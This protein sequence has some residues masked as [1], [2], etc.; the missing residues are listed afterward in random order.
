MVSARPEVVAEAAGQELTVERLALVMASVKGV[1]L[2]REAAEVISRAWI[3]YTLLAQAVASGRNLED[4]ATAAAVLWPQV[5]EALASHWHDSLVARRMPP[6]PGVADSIYNL[7]SVRLLQHVLIRAAAGAKPEERQK[8]RHKADLILTRARRGANFAALARA[9]SEDPGSK[10]EGGYLP[11]GPQGK[12]AAAFD[13]AGWR[14]KPGEISPV[15]E[16]SYGY[17]VIRRPPLDEVRPRI[18]EYLSGRVG[19]A[20]DSTY[21]KQLG[22]A[23][24]LRVQQDVPALMREALAD[25]DHSVGDDRTTLAV[26]DGGRLTVKDFMQWITALGP[27]WTPRLVNGPDSGLQVFAR[28]LGQNVLLLAQADSAGIRLPA[29]EW[30]EML[31]GYRAQLDSL[32]TAFGFTGSEITDSTTPVADRIKVA[33]S[34]V[35]SYWDKLASGTVRPK[36]VPPALAL[37]LRRGASFRVTPA[38]LVRSAGLAVTQRAAVDSAARIRKSLVPTKP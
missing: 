14:L 21:L 8:A 36:Q 31:R 37:V 13:S 20:L 23:R 26:Y 1:P 32:R 34:R 28:T 22:E 16:T 29:D 27:T 11:A 38:G 3:D 33:G 30:A 19:V 9:E 10:D 35:D 2:T 5:A 24:H 12:W 4:S 6:G 15:I 18:M 25:A 17:H 7:P